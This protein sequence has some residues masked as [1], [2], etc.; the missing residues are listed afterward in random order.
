[1]ALKAYFDDSG[2]HDHSPVVVMAGLV[3]GEAEWAALE[4][5]WEDL[6]AEFGISKFHMNKLIN[7]PW[8]SEYRGWSDCKAGRALTKFRRAILKTRSLMVGEAV[9]RD[10]WNSVCAQTRLGEWFDDPID[11]LQTMALRKALEAQR[12]RVFGYET[13]SVTFDLRLQ[14]LVSWNFF[15]QGFQKKFPGR[16]AGYSFGLTEQVLPLQAADM[17]AYEAFRFQI[18]YLRGQSE[19]KARPNFRRMMDSM[20]NRLS[21]ITEP[22]LLEWVKKVEPFVR[23]RA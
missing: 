18:D 3:A 13:V 20:E 17:V 8:K 22:D 2:T 4:T 15:A 23:R 21:F 14:N 6:K 11:F 1:M 12:A 5:E 16:F 19:P 7:R 9:S 10:A